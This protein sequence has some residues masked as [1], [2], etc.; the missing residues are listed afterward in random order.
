MVQVASVRNV[1]CKKGYPYVAV[2]LYTYTPRQRDGKLT[3][4]VTRELSGWHRTTRAALRAAN[5]PVG[6]QVVVGVRHGSPL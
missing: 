1:G 3:A 5:I 6:V 2:A 4:R